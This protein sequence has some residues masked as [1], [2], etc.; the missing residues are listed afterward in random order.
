MIDW[1]NGLSYFQWLLINITSS[2]IVFVAGV[3]GATW[4]QRREDRRYADECNDWADIQL[5]KQRD[6]DGS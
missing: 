3:A 1:I 6:S 2:V 4:Y 5:P